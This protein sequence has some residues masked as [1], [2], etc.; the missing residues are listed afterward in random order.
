MPRG[1]GDDPLSRQRKSTRGRN[2]TFEVVVSPTQITADSPEEA[3]SGQSIMQSQNLGEGAPPSDSSYNDVFFQRRADEDE[4]IVEVGTPLVAEPANKEPG[5]SVPAATPVLTETAASS[6][7]ET[8]PPLSSPV[9]TVDAS[10]PEKT[11]GAIVDSE[12]FLDERNFE[13]HDDVQTV[14]TSAQDTGFFK[15]IFGRF[16]K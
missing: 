13:R 1:L 2:R 16:R 6:A 7:V 8:A 3:M 12:G 10:L 15:R 9:P 14:E 5:E 4:P 11:E